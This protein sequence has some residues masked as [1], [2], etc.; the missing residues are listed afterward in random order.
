MKNAWKIALALTLLSLNAHAYEAMYKK[1]AVAQIEV[2]EIPRRIALET[3]AAQP[4]FREGSD[5][6]RTLF[7]YIRRHD[8]AM[9]VPVE[10]EIKPGKMRFFV[11]RKDR[12][13]QLD[14]SNGVEVRELTPLT[15]ASIGIRG[16]YSEKRFKRY[17]KKLI[18]WLGDN[19]EYEA[20]AA[21][22]AVYWNSPMIPGIFKRSEIHVPIRKKKTQ[23]KAEAGTQRGKD[24][25]DDS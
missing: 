13:R 6:F 3:T 8:V 10:A 4:Y 19:E 5:L 18:E 11:G 24:K 9:T 22:Y 1:T 16:S 2:K 7:R 21:P 23:D 20:L 17:E 25:P 12:S 15:V 14:S